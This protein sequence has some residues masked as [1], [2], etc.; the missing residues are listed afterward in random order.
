[1]ENQ[2]V[3]YELAVKLKGFG[4]DK[5]CFSYYR[6]DEKFI[7]LT[8]YHDNHNDS[9]SRVSAPLW[10]QAFD[11]FREK[12]NLHGLNSCLINSEW[13]I[14]IDNTSNSH[15]IYWS[16]TI[17]YKEARQAC[18]EKLIELIQGD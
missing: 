2:F 10:Q 11:W 12:H 13:S 15:Q 18:L 8:N 17:G 5:N 14:V 7:T 6:C 9:E 3:T 1:M 16:K 4:F